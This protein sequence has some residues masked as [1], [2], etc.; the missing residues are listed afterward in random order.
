[1]RSFKDRELEKVTIRLY[2]GD[3]ERLQKIYG[4]GNR[5]IRELVRK[6]LERKEEARR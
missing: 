6:H 5:T 3:F 4:D 1:M 2:E